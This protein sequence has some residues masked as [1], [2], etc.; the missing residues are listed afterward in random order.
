M[1]QSGKRRHGTTLLET[2]AVIGVLAVVLAG[3]VVAIGA[4]YRVERIVKDR[5]DHDRAVSRAAEQFRQDAHAAESAELAPGPHPASAVR[6]TLP[7][8]R[9]I[10][11]RL[12]AYGVARVASR[13][14]EVAHREAY[15]FPAM[16]EAGQSLLNEQKYGWSNSPDS[17]SHLLVLT[18]PA[19]AV[20]PDE[21]EPRL[22][23]IEAAIGLDAQH[24]AAE[25]TP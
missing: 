19:A 25:E 5:V 22:V 24:S 7:D 18:L 13:G 9:T 1:N 12:D 20:G 6:L 17:P 4:M 2:V 21:I 23:R 8:G 16:S 14:G 10:D 15:L 3:S 11:Y